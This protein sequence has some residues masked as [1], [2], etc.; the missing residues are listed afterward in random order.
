[1][2]LVEVIITLALVTMITGGIYAGVVQGMRANHAAAQRISAFGLCRDL[3]ENMRGSP[4]VEINTNTFPQTTVQIATL[5]SGGNILEGT[6]WAEIETFVYPPRRQVT[7]HLEWEYMNRTFR[8]HAVGVIYY[9]DRQ[10]TGSRG[11]ALSGSLNLNPGNSPQNMF[12]MR[13]SDGTLITR[14]DLVGGH[15][16]ATGMAEEIH[17]RP[18]GAGNQNTLLLNGAPFPLSNSRSYMIQ[19]KNLS[20]TLVNTTPGQGQG[21]GMGQWNLSVN[22]PEAMITVK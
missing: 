19:G 17:V 14:D 22:S 15:P 9:R 12:E 16:G 6:R 5:G 2:T 7:V 4:Y 8:E 20:V 11:G 21:Q 13:M 18:A 10:P 1:M 3:L